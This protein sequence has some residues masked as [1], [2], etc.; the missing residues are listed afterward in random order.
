MGFI[1]NNQAPI[2]RRNAAANAANEE[3]AALWRWFSGLL[4]EG[5]VR[6]CRSAGTWLVSV[7]HKH[8]ATEENFDKAVRAAR[9]RF[10]T[11]RRLCGRLELVDRV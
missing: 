2:C 4:E 5:R 3:D 11:G 1:E 9:D 8:L 6:W 7:D 10:G